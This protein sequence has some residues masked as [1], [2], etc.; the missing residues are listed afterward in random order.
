MIQN[1]DRM[2][3]ILDAP[4]KW[5][6]LHENIFENT[7]SMKD[8]VIGCSPGRHGAAQSGA[9]V[10]DDTVV[11][12]RVARLLISSLTGPR[13]FDLPQETQQNLQQEAN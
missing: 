3:C 9:A 2:K 6:H 11:S 1:S 8:N 4:Q 12:V 5:S 13:T 10:G 7:F